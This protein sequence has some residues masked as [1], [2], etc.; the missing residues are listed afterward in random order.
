MEKNQTI[1]GYIGNK[2]HC[3]NEECN[4]KEW[5]KLGMKGKARYIVVY[6]FKL[7]SEKHPRCQYCGKKMKVTIDN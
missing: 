3:Y 1:M 4:Q 7:N 5:E 6:V 2:Y